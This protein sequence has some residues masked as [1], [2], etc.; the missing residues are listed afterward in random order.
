MSKILV[1]TCSHVIWASRKPINGCVD[2]NC[3]LIY[4]I[5]LVSKPIMDTVI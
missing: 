2:N 5:D 4:G 3:V 1:K